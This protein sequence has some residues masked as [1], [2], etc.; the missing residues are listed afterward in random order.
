VTIHEAP[1]SAHGFTG[2]G[3][4][5]IDPQTGAG[6]YI[7]EG[8]GRGGYMRDLANRTM[9]TVIT[10]GHVLMS[11]IVGTANAAT[12]NSEF[13]EAM[14]TSKFMIDVMINF[15]ADFSDKVGV[16]LKSA[17][18]LAIGWLMKVKDA[19]DI[20]FNCSGMDAYFGFSLFATYLVGSFVAVTVTSLTGIG[21]IAAIMGLAIGGTLLTN[22]IVD[23]CKR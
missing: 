17:L 16:G 11:F 5:A 3:Y 19:L 1:I 6:G 14:E 12:G 13:D 15:L 4:T 23:R 10:L 7:I 8:S 18:G 2:S 9:A 22:A 20:L 21:L